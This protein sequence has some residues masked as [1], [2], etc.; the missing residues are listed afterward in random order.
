MSVPSNEKAEKD[1]QVIEDFYDLLP[2]IAQLLLKDI[3]I[4]IPGLSDNQRR[5]MHVAELLKLR[6]EDKHLTTP[7]LQ[8]ID[9]HR[10]SP[11][12]QRTIK[13]NKRWQT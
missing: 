3:Q 6:S 13:R 7:A 4:D 11:A 8:L 2:L 1:K 9:P 12:V 5:L 10:I